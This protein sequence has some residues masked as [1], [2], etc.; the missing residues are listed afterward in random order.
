M[1]NM[2][3]ADV[4]IRGKSQLAQI[5]RDKVFA[6]E[7]LRAEVLTRAV[8][9]NKVIDHER[10]WGLSPEPVEAAVVYEVEDGLITAAWFFKVAGKSASP[11]AAEGA[12]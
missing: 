7:G 9:G 11:P 1:Y 12:A 5:Y 8:M 6:R 4:G 10:T 2:P 3:H